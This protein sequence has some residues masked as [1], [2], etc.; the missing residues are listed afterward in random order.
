MVM[1]SK[2]ISLARKLDKVMDCVLSQVTDASKD[3]DKAV[4]RIGYKVSY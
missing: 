4:N 3:V 1:S 2:L